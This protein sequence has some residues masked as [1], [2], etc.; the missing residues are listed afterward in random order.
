MDDVD[1]LGI[2]RQHRRVTAK[3]QRERL[4]E[5]GCRVILEVGTKRNQTKRED[6]LRLV[7][8]GSVVKVLHTFL[9]A[10]MEKHKLAPGRRKDLLDTMAFIEKKGGTIKDVASG[11]DTADPEKRYALIA[12]ATDQLARD[13]KGL[14][15]A[16][17]NYE[18]KGR[19]VRTWTPAEWATAKAAW[20]NRKLKTWKDVEAMLPE[21]MTLS[22]AWRAFGAR[23]A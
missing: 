21:G 10:D 14:R 3:G 8:P 4:E 6:I 2:I 5:D 22:R 11:L 16:K 20:E 7:R 1:A 15:T 19:P 12:L 9:L 23:D 18:R 17:R 13:G